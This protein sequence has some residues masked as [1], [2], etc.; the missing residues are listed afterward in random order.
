MDVSDVDNLVF[1]GRHLIPWEPALRGREIERID[2]GVDHAIANLAVF[3]EVVAREGLAG[4]GRTMCLPRNIADELSFLAMPRPWRERLLIRLEVKVG[5]EQCVIGNSPEA[6]GVIG[7][8]VPR[9]VG[10]I[11]DYLT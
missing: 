4:F 10:A 11:L 7:W 2:S 8:V 5:I 9:H 1:K 3:Q 6:C